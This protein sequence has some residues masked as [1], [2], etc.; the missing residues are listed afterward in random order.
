MTTWTTI[1]GGDT[2]TSDSAAAISATAA[3]ASAAASSASATAAAA[4]V[5]AASDAVETIRG[6][7]DGVVTGGNGVIIPLYLY[8][9]DIYNN[10][11]VAALLT[12]IRTYHTVPFLCVVNPDNGPGS[13][14]IDGNYTV[15]FKMLR[16]S[17]AKVLAYVSTDYAVRS[18][19]LVRADI[20][21]WL[22]RYPDIDGVFLDEMPWELTVSGQD[23]LA[24][25]AGYTSYC[26]GLGLR[27]VVANPGTNQREE[28]FSNDDPTA[29][30]IIVHENSSY[31]AEADMRG[32]FSGGH[33]LYPH[34]K[35]AA[36]V[37]GQSLNETSFR[38]L[39]RYTQY[40]Y[41]SPDTLPNPWDTVSSSLEQQLRIIADPIRAT[42][43]SAADD[44]AAATAGVPIGGIYHNSGAVRVRLV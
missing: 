20:D 19:A 31:P 3:A 13:G 33:V 29:D 17:G 44:A 28:W 32:N 14:G 8:P 6:S 7:L 36:L 15:L 23:A 41:V 1:S 40:A 30:V 42:L 5:T 11:T 2:A 38:M 25:Y 34:T 39:L 16:G 10:A 35:R 27:P 21:S 18:S 26:H 12:L 9:S 37:Y 4:S 22:T 43:T 24:L